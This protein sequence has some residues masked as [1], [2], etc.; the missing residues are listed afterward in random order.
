LELI[1]L[2]DFSVAKK[3]IDLLYKKYFIIFTNFLYNN[4]IRFEE[5]LNKKM[6]NTES[7]RL[8]NIQFENR[9]KEK[10]YISK[11]HYNL[12]EKII[13]ILCDNLNRSTIAKGIFIDIFK[14]ID[15]KEN[16]DLKNFFIINQISIEAPIFSI[17]KLF[18]LITI[19]INDSKEEINI[20]QIVKNNN[21]IIDLFNLILKILVSNNGFLKK[22]FNSISL[23]MNI[24]GRIENEKFRFPL[25]QKF[26]FQVGKAQRFNM[27]DK[28]LKFQI[29][30]DNEII[31]TLFANDILITGGISGTTRDIFSYFPFSSAKTLPS[32]KKQLTLEE[33]GILFS[34]VTAFMIKYKF[35]SYSECFIAAFQYFERDKSPNLINC[36][37]IYRNPPFPVLCNKPIISH[38]L[39]C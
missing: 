25:L 13:D 3:Y 18:E 20:N 1:K 15:I 12:I 26:K 6:Y 8:K 37:D 31:S 30:Y 9:F 27:P 14:I 23:K 19:K 11:L 36:S 10:I 34:V 28:D 32:N 2:D 5:F 38:R 22:E 39:M 16:I 7:Q 33:F 35:H 24:L 4:N 17:K 29:F 21:I